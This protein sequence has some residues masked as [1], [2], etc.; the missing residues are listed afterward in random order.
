MLFRSVL[1]PEMEERIR[2]IAKEISGSRNVQV[3]IQ[4]HSSNE[5]D[6]T[7]NVLLS[8]ERA[9]AVLRYL[10]EKFGISPLSITTVGYGADIPASTGT[11]DKDRQMNRRVEIIIMGEQ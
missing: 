7:R 8:R 10:V 11:T 4:G 5:G 9:K 3:Y 1:R 6:R 2:E